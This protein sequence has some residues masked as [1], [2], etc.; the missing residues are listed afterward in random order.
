MI[1]TRSGFILHALALLGVLAI[2]AGVGVGFAV[3]ASQAL[4]SRLQGARALLDGT[5]LQFR[6]AAAIEARHR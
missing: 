6:L 4:Q 5:A 3:P 1:A 2:G